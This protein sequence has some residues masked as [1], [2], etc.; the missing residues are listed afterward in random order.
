MAEIWRREAGLVAIDERPAG[1]IATLRLRH[2]SADDLARIADAIGVPLPTVPNTATGD[3]VRAIW[4]GLDE[5]LIL[6]CNTPNSV[7]EATARDAASALCVDVGDGRFVLDVTGAQ[8]SD[9][10]AKGS[11]VDT[12]PSI[13]GQGQTVMTLFAQ[14]NVIIDRPPHLDGFRLYFDISFRAYLRQWFE[15]AIVEFA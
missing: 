6:G 8:A 13:F 5:W 7:I 9:L 14:V 15:D 1:R 2:P 3:V 11:S 12:H 10:L 4:I